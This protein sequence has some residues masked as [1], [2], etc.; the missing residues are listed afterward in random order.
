[1][2][3]DGGGI[4]EPRRSVHRDPAGDLVVHFNRLY[5]RC[6]RGLMIGF[7][8]GAMR[9]VRG[10]E[11][12]VQVVDVAE[13]EPADDSMVMIDVASVGICGSDLHLVGRTG[14][15]LGHEIGGWLDGRP[16]TVC[17][18]S[19]CGTC[20]NCQSGHTA[21]CQKG[22]ANV[23]GIHRDG[24]MADRVLVDRAS[25]VELP[26][27]IDAE[28]A[29]LVEPVAVGVHALNAVDIDS[30]TRIA[31]IGGGTVGLVL[32]ALALQRGC[33]VDLSARHAHQQ[34]AATALGA[35]TEPKGRYDITI[36]AAGTETAMK[37]AVQRCRTGGTLL[38]AGTYWNDVMWPG[39]TAQ[40]KELKILPVVYYGHHNGERE[41][42]T[43]ARLLA[44][45]PNLS[46]TLVT[47]R[48]S[49]NDAAE[50]FAVSANRSTGSV[51]VLLLP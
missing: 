17:P 24:G 18:I 49:L 32:A 11:G 14:V 50:G 42:D 12:R 13:P 16:V 29:C 47:H 30:S 44:E 2:A 46:P 39:M 7:R 35:G 41:L 36:D 22:A 33:T 1:M 23:V 19:Y 25:V 28:L 3:G 8:V 51:K 48:M 45:L 37:E 21:V 26:D 27:S 4:N 34:A 31:I 5:A 20:P 38:I 10:T 6:R 15:T 40:L 43:A 9:A